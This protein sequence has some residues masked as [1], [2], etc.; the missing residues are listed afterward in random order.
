MLYGITIFISALLLFQV[1]PVLARI[2]L[3]WFGGTA[4]VWASC[5]VFFQTTL[6]LGYLYAHWSA[7]YLRPLLQRW[8]HTGLL[9][10]AAALLPLAIDPAWKPSPGSDPTW[11]ILGALAASIGLPYFLLSTTGPLLQAWFARSHPGVT[12]YRLYALSNAGSLLGLLTYPV[13]VEPRLTLSVQTRVWSWG[14]GAFLLSCLLAA[15]HKTPRASKAGDSSLKLESGP[16]RR[17]FLLWLLLAFCPSLMLLALTQFVTQDVAAVPFL[18]ILPLALYLLS[19]ILCFDAPGWYVRPLFLGGL[20]LAL[21]AFCFSLFIA[22]VKAIGVPLL[23]LISSTTLF[24]TCMVC[25][26][27]LAARKP[28]AQHLTAFYLTLSIGGALGSAFGALVAPK[29]FRGNYEL[30]VAVLLAMGIGFWALYKAYPAAFRKGYFGWQPLSGFM[31]PLALAFLFRGAVDVAGDTQL[32]VRNYYGSLIVEQVAPGKE[33]PGYR[34]LTHGRILHGSQYTDPARSTEPSTYYCAD[35]GVGVALA[36]FADKPDVR[37][38]VVGLGVGTL[39]SYSRAGDQYTIYEINPLV[40]QIAR[41]RF[42][43]LPKAKSP[44]SVLIGDARQV[45]DAQPRSGYQVLAVDAFSGDSIP[46]HLLTREAMALYARH[47]APDGILAFH[48][49]SNF[50]KL[51]PVVASGVS[52]LGWISRELLQGDPDGTAGLCSGSDWILTSPS[53]ARMESGALFEKTK[54]IA[55]PTGFRP[56]TDEYSSLLQVLR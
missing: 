48:I 34:K 13:L 56:W 55:I 35:S 2:L 15:W 44:V 12:P 5:L 47:L 31:F 38:G 50:L 41:T 36:Q 21:A 6:L 40:E 43:F 1:Q 37:V 30:Y 46:V 19:F 29:V 20:P 10:G 11:R 53:R 22:P 52:P 33:N 25:H 51:A 49:S 28:G 45:M 42:E 7:T 54:P 16:G 3:P 8:V 9:M 23:L 14:M 24:W 17:Q 18:W 39:S 32:R 26:G 4:S 27:E